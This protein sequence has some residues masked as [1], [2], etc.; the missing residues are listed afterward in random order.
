MTDTL[1]IDWDSAPEEADALAQHG[2]LIGW[3]NTK[4]GKYRSE[5]DLKWYE[6]SS[7]TIIA[8]RPKKPLTEEQI[9]AV[10]EFARWDY[11]YETSADTKV[12]IWL[13]E[14]GK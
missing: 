4:T 14:R 5:R 11:Q 10:R 1:N 3:F 13:K 9:E 7:W 2:S 12:G 6:D 8:R